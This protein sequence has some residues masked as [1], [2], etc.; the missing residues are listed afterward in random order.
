ML[1]DNNGGLDRGV[2][3]SLDGQGLGGLTSRNG[4]LGSLGGSGRG[5]I[6]GL[7]RPNGGGQAGDGRG[8]LRP[9]GLG[10]VQ[11]VLAGLP[12]SLP[13]GDRLAGCPGLAGGGGPL[14][15]LLVALGEILRRQLLVAV[16]LH[17]GTAGVALSP[18]IVVDGVVA[19]PLPIAALL[20]LILALLVVLGAALRV[21][22]V[23]GLVGHGGVAFAVLLAAACKVIATVA[24]GDFV[25]CRIDD[26]EEKDTT[27]IIVL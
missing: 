14:P 19:G 18:G 22:G 23:A 15:A 27:E 6:G 8:L 5:L 20:A 25:G 7:A 16:A 13:G 2:G 26:R 21:V 17:L 1:L 9:L 12:S 10:L 4:S 3:G 24:T 11:V